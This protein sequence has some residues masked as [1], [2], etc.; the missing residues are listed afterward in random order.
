MHPITGKSM[1]YRQLISDLATKVAWQQSAA[2]KF[3]RLAQGVGGVDKG[4]RYDQ[5][6]SGQ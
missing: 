5:V 1:E 3:G 6:H 4:H 2:N